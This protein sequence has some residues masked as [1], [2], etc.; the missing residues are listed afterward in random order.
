MCFLL[1]ALV[2]ISRVIA[3]VCVVTIVTQVVYCDAA[4]ASHHFTDETITAGVRPLINCIVPLP[5][6]C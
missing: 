4:G 1:R 3:L 5:Y 6:D 2:A